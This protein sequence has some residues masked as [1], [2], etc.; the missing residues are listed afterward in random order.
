LIG[1]EKII[2]KRAYNEK[3]AQKIFNKII[4]VCN[5]KMTKSEILGHK[6]FAIYRIGYTF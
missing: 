2:A 5:G 3:I 6:E 4:K 1:A